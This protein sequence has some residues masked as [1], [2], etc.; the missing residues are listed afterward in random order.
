MF[1]LFS[2]PVLADWPLWQ[3]FQDKFIQKDGRV[4]DYQEP[5]GITTSEGQTYSLF[6][7]LVDNQPEQFE[8]LL[9]WTENN[10]AK[11][12]LS[13]NLPAWLWGR[14]DSGQWQILD[15]NSASDADI[16]LAYTLLEAAER[17]QRQDYAALG[18]ALLRLINQY[19][20]TDLP[21]LG[22]MLMPGQQGFVLGDDRWLLNPS[23]LPP[24]L[25]CA[26]A[27]FDPKG[28][29][30]DIYRNSLRLLSESERYG[31]AADWISYSNKQGWQWLSEQEQTASY[32]AIRVYMWLGM[33]PEGDSRKLLLEKYHGPFDWLMAGHHYPPE[34]IDLTTGETRGRGPAGFS[35]ALLPYLKS[36]GADQLI[37]Q[38]K[39]RI[40]RKSNG[41]LL[42]EHQHYYDQVLG[43]FAFGWMQ[44]RYQFSANG[45]LILAWDDQ[46]LFEN[47]APK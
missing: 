45:R 38:Q 2:S 6:F 42:G 43:L 46:K 19:Q 23:Y 27:N 34:Y 8:R 9:S 44:Q 16:W 21:G 40:D 20:V 14:A 12:D 13:Q 1:V 18:Y 33:M 17:W 30:A 39:T 7:A 35:A 36:L 29:W 10:L 5:P 22:K 37:S 32:D 28:P 3:A 25:F 4:I 47:A 41:E 24:Q 26:L 15:E 11:G 31:Y